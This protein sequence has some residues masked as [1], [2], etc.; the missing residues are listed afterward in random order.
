MKRALPD[1]AQL[2]LGEKLGETGTGFSPV[3]QGLKPKF[4]RMQCRGAESPALPR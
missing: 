4:L 1:R 2:Q 3:P